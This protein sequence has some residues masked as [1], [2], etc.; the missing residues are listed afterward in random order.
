VSYRQY[1]TCKCALGAVIVDCVYLNGKRISH[2]TNITSP[3][4]NDDESEQCV[5]PENL[6]AVTIKEVWDFHILEK[7]FND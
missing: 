4:I 1:H 5:S 3:K 2:V 7:I 6:K